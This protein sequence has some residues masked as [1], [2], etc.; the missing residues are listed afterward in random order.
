MVTAQSTV[1]L[2]APTPSAPLTWTIESR[3]QAGTYYQVSQ[4]TATGWSCSCPAGAFGR[5]CWHVR[6]CQAEVAQLRADLAAGIPIVDD[7][8]RQEPTPRLCGICDVRHGCDC[9]PR[10]QSCTCQP[11]RSGPPHVARLMA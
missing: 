7:G 10:M 4:V 3:T 6:A 1:S 2:P 5:Q 11:K 9:C 8:G